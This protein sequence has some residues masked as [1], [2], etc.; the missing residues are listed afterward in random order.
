[1]TRRDALRL[2]L[3]AGTLALGSSIFG[4][5][6][7]VFA[8]TA[9]DLERAKKKLEEAE[10]KLEEISAQYEELCRVHA[11]TLAKIDAVR[12]DIEATQAEID[13]KQAELD[14]RREVLSRRISAAYK[15]GPDNW[16]SILME[17]ATFDEFLSNV[18]YLDKITESDSE[19]IATVEALRNELIERR[20][21][22]EAQKAELEALSAKEEAQLADMR[23]KQEEAEQLIENLDAEVKELMKKRDEEL[24]AQA[25]AAAAAAAAR[26]G[27]TSIP[28]LSNLKGSQAAV[29]AAAY[30]TPS[31]GTGL[32]AMWVS[33]VFS[34]AGYPYVNGDACDMY[35]YYCY[36][37]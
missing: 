19:L 36:T 11:E 17:S 31:P 5:P 27:R 24:A 9:A 29:V 35:S 4:V 14:A 10:K 37:S 1:M 8:D 13:A 28:D 34:N 20:E 7:T 32:C 26:N 18:Y 30:R 12:A 6:R 23:A 25:A 21:H 15:A 16:L 2:M 33:Q 22:L 3:A